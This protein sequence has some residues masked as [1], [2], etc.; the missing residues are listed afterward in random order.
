MVELSEWARRRGARLQ[1]RPG[2]Q[3]PA[4]PTGG[5]ERVRYEGYGPGGAALLVDCLTADGKQARARLRQVFAGHGGNL[6]AAGAVSYLFHTVAV[7]AYPPGTDG[8]ALG[9]AALAAGAE[10]VVARADQSAEVLA[11]PLEFEAVRGALA[12][13]GF[14]PA[15]AE[16][17][18]RA[19]CSLT[20]SGARA[21]QMLGLLA[22]LAALEEVRD[23]YSNVEIPDEVLARL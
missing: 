21:A 23:I 1:H 2:T 10:D 3:A 19:A 9:R 11:D 18:E 8:E 14:A 17:T 16:V 15:H 6:A 5:L 22:A 12:E 20:L 4:Q 13:S 7:L